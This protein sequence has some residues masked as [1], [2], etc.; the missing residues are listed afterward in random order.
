MKKIAFVIV[1]CAC[2]LT[3]ASARA[4][5]GGFWDMLF[6]WDTKLF[7]YGTDFHI[8]CRTS[9]GQRV[10]NCEENFRNLRLRYFRHPSTT[11]HIFTAYP[12]NEA[13]KVTFDEITHEL[14]FRVS[15]MHSYG[16]R[17][18][19]EKLAPDDPHRGDT[20]KVQAV[21][22][23][24]IYTNR[25]LKWI[26]VEGGGGI[27]ALFG[28]DVSRVWRGVLTGAVV[29]PISG[30]WYVRPALSYY[31]NTITGADFGHPT[32]SMRIEPAW[33]ASFT[34]GVDLRRVGVFNAAQ[35]R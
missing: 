4:D 12:N 10:E 26:D 21:K 22:A 18:P 1:V 5:D 6:H 30:G 13:K 20:R 17:I 16:Q 7:G 33:N 28:D 24:A 15:Y 2:T 11:P 19:D 3:P 34:I 25:G 8:V 35:T 32:S 27:V 14:N 9:D 29:I 31:T 23:L